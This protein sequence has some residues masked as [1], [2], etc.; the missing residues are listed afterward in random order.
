MQTDR[1]PMPS[2]LY[3]SNEAT[4]RRSPDAGEV[5]RRLLAIGGNRAYLQVPDPYL[6]ALLSRGRTF[7]TEGVRRR[8]RARNQCH[9]NVATLWCNAPGRVRIATGYALSD[10]GL[11]RPHGWTVEGGRVIETTK[12]RAAYFGIELT[13]GEALTFTLRNPPEF[14]VAMWSDDMA[15]MMPHLLADLKRDHV[16]T[17]K[18]WLRAR[19]PGRRL[20]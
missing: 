3:P 9:R 7:P 2:D 14:L 17:V 1:R 18:N 16:S 12:R 11:W 4:I 10:D 19:G 5:R 6:P 8:R 20:T 13:I 15:A